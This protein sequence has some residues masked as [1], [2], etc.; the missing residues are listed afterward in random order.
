MNFASVF[1]PKKVEDSTEQVLIKKEENTRNG[2]GLNADTKRGKNGK[3]APENAYDELGDGYDDAAAVSDRKKKKKNGRA[4][5]SS[6]GAQHEGGHDMALR[7]Q[8]TFDA[9]SMASEFDSEE[10]IGVAVAR[11]ARKDEW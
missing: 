1:R 4:Q 6:K 5:N 8:V 3:T 10:D 9:D 2:N 11:Q 7:K